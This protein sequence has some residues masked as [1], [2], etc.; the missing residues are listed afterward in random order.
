MSVGAASGVALVAVGSAFGAVLRFEASNWISARLGHVFPWATLAVNG[1]GCF[2][3]GALMAA[4]A[5]WP[6]AVVTFFLPGLLGGFTTVSTFSLELNQLIGQRRFLRAVLYLTLS[7]L[8]MLF[9]AGV[10]YLLISVVMAR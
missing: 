5:G 4:S 3:A 9:V 8:C 2:F 1:L 10:G 7:L 6:T